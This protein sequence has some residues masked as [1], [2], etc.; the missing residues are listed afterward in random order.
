MWFEVLLRMLA[1]WKAWGTSRP[2]LGKQREIVPGAFAFT[3]P[4]LLHGRPRPFDKY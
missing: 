2:G 1:N 3:V 4:T